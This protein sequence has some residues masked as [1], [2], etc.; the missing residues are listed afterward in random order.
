MDH[1]STL[2]PKLITKTLH[3]LWNSSIISNWERI[4]NITLADS[5]FDTSDKNGVLL[6]ADIFPNILQKGKITGSDSQPT[7]YFTTLPLL[8]PLKTCLNRFRVLEEFLH[9]KISD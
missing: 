7:D 6:G 4:A 1:F 5:T 9:I 3:R 2:Y 8:V